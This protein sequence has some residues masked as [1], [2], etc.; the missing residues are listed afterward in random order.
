MLLRPDHHGVPA[1]QEEY[2][3]DRVHPPVPQAAG[4]PVSRGQHDAGEDQAR[5]QEAHPRE[6]HGRQV[7]H[8]D[9]DG[10]V[11]GAPDRA[12]EEIGDQRLAAKPRHQS[13]STGAR[14]VFS[15]TV[16]STMVVRVLTG[17]P[18]RL[19]SRSTPSRLSME[20]AATFST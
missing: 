10:E 17:W 8:P 18:G 6:E 16:E 3:G 7:H 19:I 15:N 9:A 12:D 1:E 4:E 2:S 13:A 14:P 11:G 20:G 5:D